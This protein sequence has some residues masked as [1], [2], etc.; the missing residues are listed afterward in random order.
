MPALAQ[1]SEPSAPSE[2]PESR[3]LS[4]LRGMAMLMPSAQME[5]AL[6]E[7]SD[8]RRTFRDWLLTQL[9]EGVHYGYP[10]GCEPRGN[11]K[12]KQ[13]TNKPSLYK[14]GADFMCDLMGVR[15][16]Y[17]ADNAAWEQLGKREGTFVFACRLFSR[18]GVLIGEGRGAFADGQK[19]MG[20]NAALKMAKKCAKVDAVINSWG[21]SDL[22]TQD[23]E[24][25]GDSQ[26]Q[27]RTGRQSS[28]ASKTHVEELI[29]GWKEI[30]RG[31]SAAFG[32]WAQSVCGVASESARKV[33]A[34][35]DDAIEAGWRDL[36]GGGEDAF[37]V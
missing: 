12:P 35:T 21:L 4:D 30:R 29:A 17:E 32:A 3:A 15:D 13:W 6:A 34:W 23:I 5:V 2:Q 25:Q 27:R 19:K 24:D 31:D 16:E 9:R 37:S 7:Y 33:E 28:T 10:P 8:R 11:V 26:P 20:V 1:K 18:S 14:A 36:N 22:F